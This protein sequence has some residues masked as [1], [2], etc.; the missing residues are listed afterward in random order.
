MATSSVNPEGVNPLIKI[1][2]PSHCYEAIVDSS[3]RHYS[4]R[5]FASPVAESQADRHFRIAFEAFRIAFEAFRIIK[6]LANRSAT[7]SQAQLRFFI[8]AIVA[9]GLRE[10]RAPSD[11]TSKKQ[12]VGSQCD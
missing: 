9:L 6:S 7:T 5:W 11:S 2:E 10:A 1:S 8:A 4:C 3:F 12:K